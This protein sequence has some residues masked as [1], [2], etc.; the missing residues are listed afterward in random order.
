MKKINFKISQ[1]SII[2][3]S[4]VILALLIGFE[5]I[6]LTNKIA[7]KDKEIDSLKSRVKQLEIDCKLYEHDFNQ[8]KEYR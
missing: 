4:I 8:L 2:R 1:I 5:F 6:L 7:E 3:I